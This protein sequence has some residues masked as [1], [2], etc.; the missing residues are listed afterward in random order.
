MVGDSVTGHV[1]MYPNA[2]ASRSY[3]I[4]M[5]YGIAPAGRQDAPMSLEQ[6]WS[7]NG[8]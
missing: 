1:T 4:D 6:S 5:S 7:F 3:D 2:Q 8:A